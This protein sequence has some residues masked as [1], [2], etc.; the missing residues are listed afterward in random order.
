MVINKNIINMNNIFNNMLKGGAFAIASL[1]MFAACSDDHFDVVAQGDADKTLWENIKANPNLSQF[2]DIMSRTTLLK[3]E[4]DKSAVLKLSELIDQNQSFTMVAP[5]NG[6]FDYQ[7]WADTLA[8][9]ELLR[10]NSETEREGR[11][12]MYLA[13]NQ[14]GLNHLARFSY[15]LEQNQTVRLLNGKNVQ[16]IPGTFNEVPMTGDKIIGCNGQL[17]LL[18]G[19][20]P[21]AYNLYDYLAA[22]KELSDINDYIKDPAI[23]TETF[24]ESLSMAGSLNENGDMVYIDSVFQHQNELL[25]QLGVDIENEDSCYIAL[26]PTNTGWA[27]ALDKLN[28]IYKY[29][30]SYCYGWDG[31]AFSYNTKRGT[32]LKFDNDSLQGAKAREAIITNMF[33]EPYRMGFESKKS[34]EILSYMET[35]DSLIS[36]TRTIF[37]NSAAVEGERNMHQNP[38]FDGAEIVDASNGYVVKL[39]HYN[40][41]PSYVWVKDISFQPSEMAG[42]H[43]VY[44]NNCTSSTGETINLT[45]ANYNEYREATDDEGNPI[46]DDEGNPVYTGIEGT[47]EDNYYQYYGI[48]NNST[49]MIIDFRLPEV[50]SADYKIALT[51][52]PTNINYDQVPEEQQADFTENLCFYAEVL[53][54]AE[55]SGGQVKFAYEQTDGKSD[56]NK[57]GATIIPVMKGV[58]TITLFDKFHFDKCFKDVPCPTGETF[59]RLRITVPKGGGRNKVSYAPLNIVKVIC[60]P[61]RAE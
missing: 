38:A 4:N 27:E 21:F 56:S 32:A 25:D 20:N 8:K 23:D 28:A 5:V 61:Y 57:D 58:T 51:L 7:A 53:D 35:A 49:A 47:V 45:S 1:A 13:C 2:A 11:N 18:N 39:P 24:S 6:S 46:L 54:D 17:Y 30:S 36:S 37:Y 34:R 31:T 33:F 14:F 55:V 3:S 16:S 40:F 15:N 10:A 48:Q 52:V 50:L 22:D 19:I 43:T 59:P 26:I 41:D 12:L 29:G 9:A 44:T 60:E 42:Y